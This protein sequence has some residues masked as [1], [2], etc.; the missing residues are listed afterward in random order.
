[1]KRCADIMTREVEC[2]LASTTVDQ[3]ARLMQT[4]D[5]GTT[6]V[7]DTLKDRKPI[8]LITDRDLTVRV[9]ATGR[10][11]KATKVE[12]VMT[13]DLITRAPDESIDQALKIMEERQI[14]RLPIVDNAQHLQGIITQGDVANRLRDHA[15]TA[16]LVEAVSKAPAA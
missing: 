14:R 12:E 11:P 16:E 9:L 15:K 6:V 10:D 13:R 2:C 7:V 4:K 3:I 8:G 5:I 1:M